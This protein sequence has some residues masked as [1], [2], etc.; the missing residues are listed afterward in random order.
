MN[1]PLPIYEPLLSPH[2]Y[3]L[4]A[5]PHGYMTQVAP[6][7]CAE[8]CRATDAMGP[9]RF[10]DHYVSWRPVQV[11]AASACYHGILWLITANIFNW[12]MVLYVTWAAKEWY[13]FINYGKYP[14]N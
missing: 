9:E 4:M 10:L 7:C 14:A 12:L 1:Q 13:N 2:G 11:N 8:L 3:P 5:I 6:P